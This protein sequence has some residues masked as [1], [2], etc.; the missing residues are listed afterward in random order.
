MN[1]G[2]V[3]GSAAV[4]TNEEGATSHPIWLLPFALHPEHPITRVTVIYVDWPGW[5][6]PTI[7][8]YHHQLPPTLTN[9]TATL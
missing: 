3:A 4:Q 8:T 6:H 2:C 7:S 9:S 1:K 5:P